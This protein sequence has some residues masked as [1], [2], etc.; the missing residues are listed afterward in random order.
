MQGLSRSLA[1]HF[2]AFSGPGRAACGETLFSFDSELAA[3]EVDPLV[4]MVRR[5]GVVQL[6]VGNVILVGT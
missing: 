4:T 2:V 1:P 3:D 5:G 6:A